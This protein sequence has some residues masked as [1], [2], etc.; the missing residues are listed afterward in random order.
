L[1]RLVTE[2]TSVNENID[3]VLDAANEEERDPTEAERELITR[4]RARLTELEPQ[5]SELLELEEQRGQAADANAVLNRSTPPEGGG[6]ITRATTP[7][8]P[9]SPYTHFG[10]MARDEILVRFDKVAARVGS[11]VREAAAQRLQ[12]AVANTL[13]PDI[14]GILPPQHLAQIIDVIN[15]ARP[16]VD[17]CR[18]VGLTSG[19]LT[20][21]KIKQRPTVGKQTAEKTELPSRKMQIDLMTANAE[22]F[23][24]AGDLS[25]QSVVWS[26][27]DALNLWFE[28][29]AEAYAI[30]TEGQACTDLG[31]ATTT[32]VTVGS[33]DLAGWMAAVTEAA[34][35]IYAA[36]GRRA[37]TLFTDGTVGYGLLG[38]VSA[39][40]PVFLSAGPGNLQAGTG[41]I[42]GLRLVISN[43]FGG[44]TAIVGDSQGMLCAENAGAPVELRVVEPSIAGFEVGVV[45]AFLAEVVEPGAFVDLVPP[46]GT[47]GTSATKAAAK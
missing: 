42:A 26:N 46:A 23:G 12:R 44:A 13:T 9:E 17:A 22:V 28:L 1:Q 4:H 8:A 24:G 27:P 2:R 40:A 43:G 29:A 45:G 32:S 15:R 19:V 3:R 20:Y 6:T 16:V 21:P 25:W 5:I 39:D 7:E 38:M 36:T 33:D 47:G 37:D 35:A 30:A 31:A 10:Q 41:T 18:S 14:P 34:G 11:D